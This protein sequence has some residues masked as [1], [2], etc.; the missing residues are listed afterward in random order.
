MPRNRITLTTLLA[1]ALAGALALAP[2]LAA[3]DLGVVDTGPEPPPVSCTVTCIGMDGE[4]V[5][6]GDFGPCIDT[7][8]LQEATMSRDTLTATLVRDASTDHGTLGRLVCGAGDLE[9]H[10]MEPPWRDNAR[11]RSHIPAGEY[12]LVPHRSPRYG[13]C[14][15]FLETAPRTHVLVH[16]GNVGGDVDRG[17]H[18]H[19]E[20]CLLPGL[21]RGWLTVR[22]KRQRAV[23]AS[24]T[25][26]RHWMR[27]AGGRPV[28]MSIA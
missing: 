8:T 12:L 21:R 13:A 7:Y 20:A 2:H 3:A 9:L 24:R 16:P 22:G 14:Y 5:P 19:T 4:A 10:T 26:F 6:C 23:L 11:G 27:W 1:A 25:A 15:L 28:E 17:W 18:S